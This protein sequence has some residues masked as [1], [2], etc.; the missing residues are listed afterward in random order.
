MNT[1]MISNVLAGIG[2]LMLI[3]AAAGVFSK[4]PSRVDHIKVTTVILGANTVFL[5]AIL[6]KL[7]DKK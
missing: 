6:G 1:K 3:V 7:C 2:V 4:N 5:L